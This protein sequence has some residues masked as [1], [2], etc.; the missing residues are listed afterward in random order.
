MGVQETNYSTLRFLARQG[1]CPVKLDY[2]G[3]TNSVVQHFA[4]P[5]AASALTN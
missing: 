4:Q 5:D 3:P 1:R 2:L